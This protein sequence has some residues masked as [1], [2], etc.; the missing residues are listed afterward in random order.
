[1]SVSHQGTTV[2]LPGEWWSEA[3]MQGFKRSATAYRW[4][5]A[6]TNQRVCLIPIADIEPVSPAPGVPTFNSSS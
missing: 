1:M 3:G 4:D 2:E 5:R 6:A